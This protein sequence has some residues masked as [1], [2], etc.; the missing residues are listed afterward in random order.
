[1]HSW[2]PQTCLQTSTTC[3]PIKQQT[4]RPYHGVSD[5]L[6]C[7]LVGEWGSQFGQTLDGTDLGRYTGYRWMGALP[8]ASHKL[9]PGMAQACRANES[10]ESWH[11]GTTVS[12]SVVV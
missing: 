9:S 5:S 7:T 2:F 3:M 4:S 12:F 1:M 6:H 10:H 8:G 11:Q